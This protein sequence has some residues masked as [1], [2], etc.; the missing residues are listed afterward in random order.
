MADKPDLADFFMIEGCTFC[1]FRQN[2]N[3]LLI[4]LGDDSGSARDRLLLREALRLRDTLNLM[5]PKEEF[6]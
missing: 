6:E 1:L 3:R 4:T 5:Y 2:D